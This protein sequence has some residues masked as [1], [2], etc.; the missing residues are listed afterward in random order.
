MTDNS[1][2]DID[3]EN[4]FILSKFQTKDNFI[5]YD[6]K[7]TFKVLLNN[8]HV[9]IN[10]N[11]LTMTESSTKCY[12][13]FNAL[14]KHYGKTRTYFNEFISDKMLTFELKSDI[15]ITFEIIK[16]PRLLPFI[17]N[18]IIECNVCKTYLL[19]NQSPKLFTI[20]TNDL[21]HK[22]PQLSNFKNNVTLYKHDNNSLYTNE[23]IIQESLNRLLLINNKNDEYNNI[24]LDHNNYN[25]CKINTMKQLL[26]NHHNELINKDT[27]H[28]Y[29][30][31]I[32]T[33][34]LLIMIIFYDSFSK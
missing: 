32:Y 26:I 13:F 19:D 28:M 29:I 3:C 30:K 25:I 8:K 27:V 1:I 7:K 9:K 5:C 23:L 10:K 17:T 14:Y 18:K 11:T 34:A 2:L 24:I 6:S 31:F 4:E 21:I 15:I 20:T 16:H 12:D 33:L 22:Y